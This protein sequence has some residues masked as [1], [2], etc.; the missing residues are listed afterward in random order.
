MIGAMSFGAVSKEAKIAIARAAAR[1]GVAVNT[2][3]G[4]MLPEERA[5]A[6]VLVVQY[7]SGRFGVSIDYL[8]RADAVEIKI[9]QGAKPGQGGLLLGDK[10]TEE[11]A[12]IRGIPE[13]A[14]AISPARHLDI[15]GPEDLKMKIEELR[16]AT[17]WKVPIAVKVA[18]GR[19]SD[20]VKIAAKA[21]ADIVVVDCKP[22]GTGA[23]P[24]VVAEHAGYPLMAATVQADRALRELGL[25]DEVSLVVSGGVRHGA[26]V[27]KL[28]ALGANAVAL[29]TPVLMA[30]G[31]TGCGLCSTGRCPVGIATQSPGLRKRLN[32]DEA[33]KRVENYLRSVIKE[34]CMMAQLAGKTSPLNLEKEDLRALTVDASAITGVKLVGAEAPVAR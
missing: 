27:A 32:V 22:A 12:E 16:E 26:D 30:M 2:G 23:S 11:I 20:D 5:E 13:G 29:S 34:L 14:D 9:G 4:G 33:A 3:E 10:V 6:S 21:G 8:S 18:A 31:C 17:D 7:A 28:L 19:V 25:R 1:V 15:V 24:H